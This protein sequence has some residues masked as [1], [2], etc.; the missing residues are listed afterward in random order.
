MKEDEICK[1]P[2]TGGSLVEEGLGAVYVIDIIVMLRRQ[3]V[4]CGIEY[5]IFYREQRIKSPGLISKR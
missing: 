1:E 3:V 4:I 2:V 5:I